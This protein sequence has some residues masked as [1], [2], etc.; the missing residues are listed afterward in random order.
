MKIAVDFDGTCVDHDYPEVGKEVPN[1][2]EVL[3]ALDRRGDELFLFTMRS[4]QGLR[5]A[6]QWFRERDIHLS[7][8]QQDPAQSSW[9]QSPKCYAELYID[10]AAFGCP[11]IEVAG[12][13]RPCVDWTKVEAELLCLKTSK[14]LFS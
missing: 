12:F 9:T 5:D 3:K 14:E 7:G 10:D 4:G 2:V 6:V 1:C 13:K 8:I 11:L